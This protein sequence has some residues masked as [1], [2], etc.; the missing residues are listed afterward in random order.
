MR[1]AGLAGVV[2]RQGQAHHGPGRAPDAAA[3]GPARAGLH[4]PGAEPALGR[5]HHLRGRPGPG[6]STSPSSST[7]S[8]AAIVG[9]RR[10]DLACAPTWPWT[11]SSTALWHPPPRRRQDL[12]GLVHHSDRGVQY[13]SIRY[14]ERLAEAGAVASVGSH[15]R[16]LRQ[17]RRRVAH[18]P[19]QDRTDPPPRSL[20]GPRRRRARHPG[21]GRL[22]QP[23]TA[24]RRTAATSRPPSTRTTTTVTHSPPSHSPRQNR[25]STE[26][27]A[28]QGRPPTSQV[29]V[30]ASRA[31]G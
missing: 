30:A 1:G 12:T 29:R 3:G 27:G 23:P 24:A 20:E 31:A 21:M 6:S 4:R 9:W 13:L 15:G 10:L 8:P 26:P 25:A 28:V 11:P 18:R 17:R 7:C 2:A 22:V 19:V 5:R 14:T 16:L